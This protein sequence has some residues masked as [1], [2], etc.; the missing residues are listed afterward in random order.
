MVV[1]GRVKVTRKKTS[2]FF[3]ISYAA[4]AWKFNKTSVEGNIGVIYEGYGMVPHILNRGTIPPLFGRM[5]EQW[6]RLSLIQRSCRLSP[7]N[8]QEPQKR[9]RGWLISPPYILLFK[10]SNQY[11]LGNWSLMFAS[12]SGQMT[13]AS[14]FS[15]HFGSHLPLLFKLH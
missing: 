14:S 15:G 11:N 7:Y 13:L 4:I 5:T 2:S 1:I 10:E 12:I 8:I 6:Q 9:S 3:T